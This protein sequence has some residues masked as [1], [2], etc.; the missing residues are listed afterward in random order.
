MLV[1]MLT[2]AYDAADRTGQHGFAIAGHR[3]CALVAS[4][5]RMPIVGFIARP[6]SPCAC[7]SNAWQRG[8]AQS[9]SA[10]RSGLQR[11]RERRDRVRAGPSA[12]ADRLIQ[13][14]TEIDLRRLGPWAAVI[15]AGDDT[16]YVVSRR[17]QVVTR[18]LALH[19]NPH[20]MTPSK[21]LR[22]GRATPLPSH[23]AAPAF[24]WPTGARGGL[25]SS[26]RSTSV[27]A[28]N[29]ILNE[30]LVKTG[31]LG[32]IAPRPGLAHPRALALT[33]SGDDRDDD[34]T[35]Y[36]TEFF[37][38]PLA[39]GSVDAGVPVPGSTVGD[40]M[41]FERNRQGFVFQSNC[42]AGSGASR[43]PSSPC[44]TGSPAHPIRISTSARAGRRAAFR[45][46]FM[47]R[48]SKGSVFSSTN[49][50]TS[51]AGPVGPANHPDGSSNP[52]NFKTVVHPAVFVVDTTTNQEM[53]D[54][55]LVLTRKLELLYDEDQE[56]RRR[57]PLIPNDIAIVKR[58][59]GLRAWVTALGADAVYGIDYDETG[60]VT[61]GAPRARYINLAQQGFV[62]GHLPIGIATSKAAN[63]GF[64]L[65]LNDATQNVTVINQRDASVRDVKPTAELERAV[66][67][68]DSSVNRG[69]KLFATGLD[70]WS[71][72][73][74]AWLS[75]ESCHPDGLSDG[76][77]WFFSRGP[78]RTIS[79]A[80]TYD[81][82]HNRRVMLWTG[83]IDEIHDI[84]SIVRSVA[85]GMGGNPLDVPLG[86]PSNDFRILFDGSA[87]PKGE[88]ADPKP[89]STLLNNLNGSLASI[90]T[91][92][93]CDRNA[94]HCDSTIF[95]DWDEI[96]QYIQA[97]R[98]PRAPTGVV[99]GRVVE[100]ARLFREGRCAG[101]HGG[102]AFTLSKVFYSPGAKF[103]G[104]LPLF[105]LIKLPLAMRWR[106][107]SGICGPR[108]TGYRPSCSS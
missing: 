9:G 3:A 23:R 6:R 64:A 1:F 40:P 4:P 93:L 61:V 38:Q 18:I 80:G 15:D 60:P 107:C 50:C 10:D 21:T 14:K 108:D 90:I 88:N 13:R 58:P 91:G 54:Q 73:G 87:V 52:A 79:T 20:P 47:L 69:R 71:L 89:S 5:G 16:A 55:R 63:G 104:A 22:W 31:V 66:K 65:V 100:G 39:A 85:G 106:H 27:T 19:T 82:N 41:V 26:P 95:R 57:F 49:M 74:Q 17:H 28:G 76:V 43:L 46:S 77:T 94:D 36:V 86:K 12:P 37:S 8:R 75:C 98:A 2:F 84:E 72:E 30:A 25:A 33:D 81:R 24:S 105:E 7:R 96:D 11:A 101:C 70:G 68:R 34:E 56:V 67:V 102:P 92:G 83:N 62:G 48:P 35:L 32:E 78:R 99:S 51:P 45:I 29:C 53:P 97:V 103:N 44:S 59:G 42:R